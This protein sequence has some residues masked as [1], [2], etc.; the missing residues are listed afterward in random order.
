MAAC[1]KIL[2]SSCGKRRNARLI[3]PVVDS[4][5][6]YMHGTRNIRKGRTKANLLWTHTNGRALEMTEFNDYCDVRAATSS[7]AS[8]RWNAR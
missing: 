6:G 1:R 3:G 7:R 8:L 5:N 4:Q 2:T